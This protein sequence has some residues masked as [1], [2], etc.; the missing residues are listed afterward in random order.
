MSVDL[1]LWRYF[2]SRWPWSSITISFGTG[3]KA[4]AT[5][6]GNCRHMTYMR[7]VTTVQQTLIAVVSAS[8]RHG[9]SG[10][11]VLNKRLLL[12]CRSAGDSRID[13]REVVQRHHELVVGT[14]SC[15]SV[16]ARVVSCHYTQAMCAGRSP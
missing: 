7:K 4:A 10:S 11:A 5:G 16:A 13:S 2:L 3:E 1:T 9:V 6:T 14:L 12:H 8:L 15:Y